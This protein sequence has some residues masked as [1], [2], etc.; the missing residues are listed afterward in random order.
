MVCK[1]SIVIYMIWLVAS[2][3]LKKRL[4]LCA[5]VCTVNLC[6]ALYFPSGFGL[7]ESVMFTCTVFQSIFFL[8]LFFFTFSSN[9]TP[10]L[11]TH[12]LRPDLCSFSQISNSFVFVVV[13]SLHQSADVTSST[14]WSHDQT[15]PWQLA[16]VGSAL[17]WLPAFKEVIFKKKN[18][19]GASQPLKVDQQR[20][21]KD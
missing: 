15:A 5:G 1:T 21:M 2:P 19:C 3:A 14:S 7:S 20:F 17:L 12:L 16:V 18:K 13:V 9:E 10:A 8:L 6:E 11:P 4:Y